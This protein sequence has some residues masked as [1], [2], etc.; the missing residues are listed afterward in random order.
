VSAI[1]GVYFLDGQPVGCA[2]VDRMVAIQAHRGPDGSGVW[3]KG[4]VGVGHCLLWT[5]P[6]SLREKFPRISRAGELVLTAD[7]R[8]DNRH[9]LI[10][11]L[12]RGDRSPEE[13]TDGPLILAAYERWGERSP[14]RLLGDFAFVV[15][16]GRTQ[17]LLCVRDY[18]G[19][20][21][22]YYYH[23]PGRT[24]SF[25]S[26]IKAL[27]C[28]PC[29]PRRLNEVRVADYLASRVEDKVVTFYQDI[30][31]LPPPIA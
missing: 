14:E 29:V 17:S 21:P 10:A 30:F 18:F 11:A 25:A 6:E 22:F 2:D 20:K 4:P 16:D 26:E 8:I 5:T 19:I 31:R 23:H 7:A 9:A 13:L 28:L 1:A 24:F 12:N 3:S 27:M 15:W